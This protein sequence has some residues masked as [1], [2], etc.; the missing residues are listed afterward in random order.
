MTL[1]RPEPQSA[2]LTP[3]FGSCSGQRPHTCNHKRL[4][5]PARAHDALRGAASFHAGP[6][7]RGGRAHPRRRTGPGAAAGLR[8][9]C[10]RAQEGL[11]QGRDPCHQGRWCAAWNSALAQRRR[12]WRSVRSK[13]RSAGCVNAVSLTLPR[14]NNR[15]SST[16]GVSH[17]IFICASAEYHSTHHDS[18]NSLILMHS[19]SWV[20]RDCNLIMQIINTPGW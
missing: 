2:A 6:A 17:D 1:N 14:K 15:A 8:D 10:V 19:R 18:R 7:G 20:R 13:R 11:P 3:C 16:S 9:I 5:H 4:D 12:I